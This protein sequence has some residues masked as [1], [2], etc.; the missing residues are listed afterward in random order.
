MIRR[1]I[2]TATGRG[3]TYPGRILVQTN[4]AGSVSWSDARYWPRLSELVL[5]AIERGGPIEAWIID[6]TGF[7]KK[8]RHSVGVTREYCGQLGKRG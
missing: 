8:G 2:T 6:G 3:P 4:Q 5:P 1:R 7:L